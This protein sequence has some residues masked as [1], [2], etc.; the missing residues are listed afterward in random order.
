M[1]G[2]IVLATNSVDSHQSGAAARLDLEFAGGGFF[3]N[4]TGMFAKNQS[5]SDHGNMPTAMLCMA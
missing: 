2:G 5:D 1:Y 4:L 3:L